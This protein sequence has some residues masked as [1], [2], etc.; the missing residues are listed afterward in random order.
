MSKKDQRIFGVHPVIEALEAG[1]PMEKILV[2]KGKEHAR[3]QDIRRVAREEGIPIQEVPDEKLDRL[4]RQGNHQG[5]VA[6]ASPVAYQDLEAVVLGLQEQGAV[7]LLLLLDGVTDVRNF[8]A[9]ARTAEAMGAQALIVPSRG[10][11]A[12]N[13]D[14]IRT[15]AGALSHL[16]VCRVG[17]PV[18]AVLLLQ[19][20]GIRSVG[21]TEK[22]ERSLLDLELTGPLCLVLGSEEKG[23]QNQLIRRVEAVGRIPMTGRV[24][25][26]NVSVAAGMALMEIARQRAAQG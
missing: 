15:S 19:A 22:T 18:D 21:C 25:S 7:P 4:S 11:A 8:G 1:Q 24:E 13:E 26:L 9:I 6:L 3:I 16:P 12:L 5:V 10:S 23:I 14:A 2:R 17:H 20:Y